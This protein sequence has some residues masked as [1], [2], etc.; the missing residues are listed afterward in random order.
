MTRRALFLLSVAAWSAAD[1]E[2][3]P[4]LSAKLSP[5]PR[6]SLGPFTA[7]PPAGVDPRDRLPIGTHRPVQGDAIKKGKWVKL[8]DGR[9][10]WRLEIQ[11]PGAKRLRLHFEKFAVEKGKVWLLDGPPGDVKVSGPYTGSG[12][13]ERGEFWS[14]TVSGDVVVI[15]FLPDGKAPKLP[16]FLLKEISHLY[17]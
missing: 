12:I 4:S 10:V 13:D 5:P 16:P 3:P 6:W 2:K 9:R 7:S 17:Q 1:G 14:D 11:S 8:P 15:E